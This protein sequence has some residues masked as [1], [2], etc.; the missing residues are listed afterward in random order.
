MLQYIQAYARKMPIFSI[1]IFNRHKIS[2]D[3]TDLEIKSMKKGGELYAG[4]I[5]ASTSKNLLNALNENNQNNQE[6]EQINTPKTF[7]KQQKTIE[8]K[9]IDLDVGSW[10][11]III[12]I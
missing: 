9:S 10:E 4:D 1:F 3:T 8:I 12:K 5:F 11:K 6:E 7:F 2:V